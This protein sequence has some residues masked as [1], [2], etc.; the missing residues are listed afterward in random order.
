MITILKKHKFAID[1]LKKKIQVRSEQE[2]EW[3]N[4]ICKKTGI[5][6]DSCDSTILFDHIFNDC[7]VAESQIEFK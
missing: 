5:N 6:P 1:D 4:D 7:R 3:F 2:T